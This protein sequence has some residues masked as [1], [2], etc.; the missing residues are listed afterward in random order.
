MSAER[1]SESSP[2]EALHTAGASDVGRV[3]SVNQDTLHELHDAD[4]ARHLLIVADGM[5]GHRGGEVASRLAVDSIVQS[6]D[7]S[8]TPP[9]EL[10]QRAL[11]GANLEV[12][13]ASCN[14]ADLRG[15]GTTVVAM[16]FD[17]TDRAWVAHVG[18]SRAYL[19]RG[20]ELTQLTDD[21]SVVG[22]LVRRGQL[23]SEEA[24]VHPQSNEILRA[25]GTQPDV[26]VDLKE[27]A[28]EPGDRYLLCSDGLSGMLPDPQIAEE[29]GASPPTEAVRRLI[30]LANEA[31]GTDNITVQ[32]A[33]FDAFGARPTRNDDDKV[34]S[35]PDD[36]GPGLGALPWLIVAAAAALVIAWLLT[37]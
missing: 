32:V 7:G 12:F 31:G 36:S 28:I 14:D 15:M 34:R 2:L 10:L 37:N 25:I 9:S 26:E 11:E 8:G 21:H 23:T 1:K 4:G 16:L 33:H 6:V 22:E 19:L 5:G 24:R 27:I 30:D 29:L 18:D 17:E 13:E 20:N 35:V 3:R